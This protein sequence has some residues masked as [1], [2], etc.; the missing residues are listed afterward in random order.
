MRDVP[1]YLGTVKL[2]VTTAFIKARK[3][4]LLQFTRNQTLG[5]K[6]RATVGRNL[7]TPEIAS[8]DFP[9]P[10]VVLENQQTAAP[11]SP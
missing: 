8:T 4:S 1:Q 5:F 6:L 3:P 9:Q 2:I 11:K 10:P 7:K